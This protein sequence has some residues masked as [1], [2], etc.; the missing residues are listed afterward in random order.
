MIVDYPQTE[1]GLTVTGRHLERSYRPLTLGDVDMGSWEI[2]TVSV[3]VAF[4][5]ENARFKQLMAKLGRL[6]K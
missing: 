1:T 2:F 3:G 4:I 6:I 5:V